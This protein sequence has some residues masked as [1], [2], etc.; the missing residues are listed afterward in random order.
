MSDALGFLSAHAR[1]AL[2]QLVAEEVER[3]LAERERARAGSPWLTVE[4]A[5]QYLRLSPKSVR[6]RLARLPHHRLDGRILLRRDE[7]DAALSEKRGRA[8]C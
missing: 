5:A 6:N 1:A 3:Q 2:L 4:E 8:S 7:L